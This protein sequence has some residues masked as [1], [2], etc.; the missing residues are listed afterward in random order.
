M[1]VGVPLCLGKCAGTLLGQRAGC[2]ASLAVIGCGIAWL[3]E[4]NPGTVIATGVVVAGSFFVGQ[5]APPR[6]GRIR[7]L[8]RV[9]HVALFALLTGALGAIWFGAGR[10]VF[11]G[12][13]AIAIGAYLIGQSTKRAGN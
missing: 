3:A 5:G 9:P 12:M 4:I 8:R 13:A 7:T 1:I 11:L 10:V 2:G 6:C